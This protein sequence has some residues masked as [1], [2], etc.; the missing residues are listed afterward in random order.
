M[1]RKKHLLHHKE[2]DA[3]KTNF[4]TKPI[5]CLHPTFQSSASSSLT[6]ADSLLL[7]LQTTCLSLPT[8]ASFYP[9]FLCPSSG[10]VKNISK[11]SNTYHHSDV[12]ISVPRLKNTK[13]VIETQHLEI[14]LKTPCNCPYCFVPKQK[15][16][17]LFRGRDKCYYQSR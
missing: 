6:P 17:T 13:H 5:I 7:L 16:L 14:A 9:H 8:S 10:N 1:G 12:L 3:F 4:K 11:P 2:S 15:I